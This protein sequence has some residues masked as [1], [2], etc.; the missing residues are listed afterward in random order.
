[1]FSNRL[2]S[3]RSG[4][5]ATHAHTPIRVDSRGVRSS[6]PLSE[7]DHRSDTKL[8]FQ[9][10]LLEC[11]G[12]TGRQTAPIAQPDRLNSLRRGS[13]WRF[14]CGRVHRCLRSLVKDR[15]RI[16]G[17][18]CSRAIHATE[19]HERQDDNHTDYNSDDEIA[20]HNL[21]PEVGKSKTTRL[22]LDRS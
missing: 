17:I 3:P 15:R 2:S 1:M 18:H 5:G 19:H 21:A 6:S 14:R 8:R 13:R 7:A 11:N 16:A 22:P 20:V 12:C 9:R 10:S 4:F